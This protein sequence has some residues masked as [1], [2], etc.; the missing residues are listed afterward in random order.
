VGP[1]RSPIQLVLGFLPEETAAGARTQP[2]TP[3][4][5]KVL[6]MRGVITSIPPYMPSCCVQE[7]IYLSSVDYYFLFW[8]MTPCTDWQCSQ[9]FRHSL[10]AAS[11]ST[12]KFFRQTRRW[13]QR[14]PPK[15]QQK[16]PISTPTADN[17]VCNCTFRSARQDPLTSGCT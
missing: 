7:Q 4:P 2:F 3:I 15:R 17:T 12:R 9:T 11:N 16:V 5:C 10:L 8:D 1:T 6:R 13:M 14:A